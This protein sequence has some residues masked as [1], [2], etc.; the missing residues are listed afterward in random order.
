MGQ[1]VRKPHRGQSP[2]SATQLPI[3]AALHARFPTLFVDMIHEKKE[4]VNP[5]FQILPLFT[6]EGRMMQRNSTYP[7]HGSRVFPEKQE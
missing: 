1:R 6:I 5:H 4:N 3:P 7:K 2:S